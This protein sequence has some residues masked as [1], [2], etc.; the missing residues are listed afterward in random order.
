AL[1]RWHQRW[2]SFLNERTP[3]QNGNRSRYS[4]P[5]LRSAFLSL[6]RNRPWL[7][8]CL[9]YPSLQIPNTTNSLDGHFAQLKSMLRN[10]NGLSS[11]NKQNLVLH[12]LNPAI[13]SHF[14]H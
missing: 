10:H 3:A 9:R 2:I 1:Q 11:L 13:I 7:F 14:D 6:T 8:T 12:L 4:H 5:R